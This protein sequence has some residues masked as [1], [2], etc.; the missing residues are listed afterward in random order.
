MLI[1]EF[2]NCID[3]KNRLIVPARFRDELGYKCI[4]SKGLDQCLVLYPMQTWEAQA[5]KLA[6]LPS[7]DPLARAYKRFIYASAF[8]CE[9][10]KQG[11]ILIPA[12]LKT[13]AGIEKDLVTIGSQDRV[14]IWS[15]QIYETSAQGAQISADAFASFSDKY[16]V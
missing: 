2:Q 15:K 1:G 7:S 8:E 4:L 16:Q 3:E 10:D 11:R 13:A 12:N 14:E 5:Q 6:A 9:I